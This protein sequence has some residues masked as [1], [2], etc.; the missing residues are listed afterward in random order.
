MLSKL[1]FTLTG[2]ASASLLI[3]IFQNFTSEIPDDCVDLNKSL[4]EE[5]IPSG[6][7]AVFRNN[8]GSTTLNQVL[9]QFKKASDSNPIGN[10]PFSATL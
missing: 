10:S 1:S 5:T 8:G 4:T 7:C 2:L 3:F 6:G 9:N